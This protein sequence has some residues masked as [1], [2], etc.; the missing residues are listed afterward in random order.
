MVMLQKLNALH[1][2]W[3]LIFFMHVPALLISISIL[4]S[5][6]VIFLAHSLIQLVDPKSKRYTCTSGLWLLFPSSPPS[7]TFCKTLNPERLLPWFCKFISDA[8][9]SLIDFAAISPFSVFRQSKRTRAPRLAKS[10]AVA[11][12]IPELPPYNT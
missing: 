7:S 9:W 6:F 5:F 3:V 4:A 2:Y 10:N 12:P 8:I 11:F 1:F